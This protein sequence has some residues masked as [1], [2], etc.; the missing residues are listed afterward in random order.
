[1]PKQLINMIGIK[2]QWKMG[3]LPDYFGLIQSS[4]KMKILMSFDK[5]NISYADPDKP[6][7]L[8]TDITTG[9]VKNDARLET[10]QMCDGEYGLLFNT[11]ITEPSKGDLITYHV[12]NEMEEIHNE[13]ILSPAVPEEA[14]RIVVRW[15]NEDNAEFSGAIHNKA[16]PSIP[17]AEPGTISYADKLIPYCQQMGKWQNSFYW[18]PVYCNP[19]GVGNMIY[20]HESFFAE[21]VNTR[22]QAMTVRTNVVPA[23]SGKPPFAFFV[24]AIGES[25]YKHSDSNLRVEVYGYHEGQNPDFL[26]Y[27]PIAE[28]DIKGAAG[29]SSNDSAEYWHVFNLEY[30][31]IDPANPSKDQSI[32]SKNLTALNGRIV[33]DFCEMQRVYSERRV[34]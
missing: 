17:G 18:M 26:I 9:E 16:I 6:H 21:G 13:I 28:F 12:N 24:D 1:M 11:N 31:L 5:N 8:F 22:A 14:F 20:V 32:K 33:T 10:N 2:E 4:L 19:L 15:T 29:T 7:Y 3:L 34:Q 25:I 27:N 23:D 30:A